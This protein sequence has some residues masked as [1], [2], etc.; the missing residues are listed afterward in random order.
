MFDD[1][2]KK[3]IRYD[4]TII[5]RDLDC[6]LQSFI[7]DIMDTITLNLIINGVNNY[8]VGYGLKTSD[9]TFDVSVIKIEFDKNI[10]D[11]SIGN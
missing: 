3:K 8:L 1:I 6:F 11:F 7:Y 4:L 10:L 9:I 2:I 5:Q